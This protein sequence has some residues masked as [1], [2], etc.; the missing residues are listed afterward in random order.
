MPSVLLP[1][2]R[3]APWESHPEALT[4]PDMKLS[5]HPASSFQQLVEYRHATVSPADVSPAFPTNAIE[6]LCR[7]LNPLYFH[8]AHR[9]SANCTFAER[10]ARQSNARR[11]NE[12]SIFLRG[13]SPCEIKQV[14]HQCRQSRF[15]RYLASLG[16]HENDEVQGATLAT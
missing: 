16:R 12:R 1:T 13:K 6:A 3:V 2:C 11:S 10:R 7:R 9:A 8:L 14:A 5:P 15:R 4:K